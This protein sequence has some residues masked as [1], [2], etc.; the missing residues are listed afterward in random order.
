MRQAV[1]V[2]LVDVARVLLSLLVVEELEV[3]PEALL[4]ARGQG[5]DL[6]E[7]EGLLV[8]RGGLERLVDHLHLA[9][10]D[11]LGDELLEAVQRERLADGALQV[12]VVGQG[13][14]GLRIA[15]PG[16][17]LRDSLQQRLHL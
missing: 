15:E 9:L 17:V 14:R 5:R 7:L 13:H 4:L 11:L 16:S 10:A 3:V 2:R 8:V 1:E 6:L 12:S